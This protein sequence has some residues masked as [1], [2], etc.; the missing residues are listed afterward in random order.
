MYVQGAASATEAVPPAADSAAEATLPV[1][2]DQ[3]L[4]IVAEAA[5]A[6]EAAPVWGT[7]A[8]VVS[9]ATARAGLAAI[10][11]ALAADRAVGTVATA[12]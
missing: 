10:A 4:A 7:G 9:A 1:P 11:V 6:T 2:A 12:A 8:A 5:S 3:V